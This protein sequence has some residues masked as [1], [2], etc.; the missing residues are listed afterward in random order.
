M[1][2][3]DKMLK[4]RFAVSTGGKGIP[5]VMEV[6]GKKGVKVSEYEDNGDDKLPYYH[7]EESVQC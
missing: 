1:N 6:I 7:L 4:S 3:K 2:E 5:I